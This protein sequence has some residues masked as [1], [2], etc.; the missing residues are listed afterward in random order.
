MAQTAQP[1]PVLTGQALAGMS[2]SQRQ[3]ALQG[4]SAQEQESALAEYAG[5][6]ADNNQQWMHQAF[7]KTAAAPIN[8][9]AGGFQQTFAQGATLN[10]SFPTAGGAY[11]RALVFTCNLT[12]TLAAGTGAGYTLGVAGPLGIFSNLLV[13]LN[14]TQH[15]FPPYILK[16]LAQM[17]GWGRSIQ[18]LTVNAGIKDTTIEGVLNNGGTYPVAVGANTW[19]FMFRVPLNA[20]SRVQPYGLLPMMNSA[21]LPTV[22]L[23]VN[24]NLVGPDPEQNGIFASSGTGGAVSSVSGTIQMDVEYSDGQTF[25]SP[26]AM[27]LD[28]VGEPT[29]QYITDNIQ[30]NIAANSYQRCKIQALFQHFAVLAVYM[31]GKVGGKFTTGLSNIQGIQLAMDSVGQNV[32]QEYGVGTNISIYDYYERMRNNL[33]QDFDEGV[34]PWI[35]AP[36][37]GIQNPSAS[38]GVQFL[39]MMPGGWPDVTH[40][41]NFASVGSVYTPRIATYLVSLNP[42]GL[43]IVTLA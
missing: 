24:S 25:Y 19:N 11:A 31:D 27:A 15:Q 2:Q 28:L 32:F 16:Y 12:I 33:G 23:T 17:L 3:A 18:P 13:K 41:V 39:N 42:A 1:T 36:S 38:D 6:R 37:S 22:Q 26:Q 5:I 7:P 35:H 4:A 9:G 21:T 30:Q 20:I 29:V 8:S 10:W 14:G 34:V 43:K 40:A